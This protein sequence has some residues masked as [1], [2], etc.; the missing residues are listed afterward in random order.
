MGQD[1]HETKFVVHKQL[2]VAFSSSFRAALMGPSVGPETGRIHLREEDSS[3]FRL[4]VHWLYCRSIE[5][6]LNNL[7]E[8]FDADLQVELW[9][10]GERYVIP[11]LQHQLGKMI[12][13]FMTEGDIDL[14]SREQVK[15]VYATT[16]PPSTLRQ[17]V[18]DW[19]TVEASRTNSPPIAWVEDETDGF[20]ERFLV[21]LTASMARRLRFRPSEW[22]ADRYDVAPTGASSETES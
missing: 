17:I 5:T 6:V 3:S 10:L 22:K 18:V 15:L 7:R 19:Y 8:R 14:P 13:E 2:L 9:A 4:F 21:D 1:Q 20:P 12:V 16:G 11:T